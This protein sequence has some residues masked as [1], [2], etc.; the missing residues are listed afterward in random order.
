MLRY[1]GRLC[2][3]NIDNL[4][5]NIVAEAHGS[6]YYIHPGYTKMYNDLKDIYWSEGMKRDISM[7]VD[8]SQFS[9]C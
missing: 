8:E 9:K 4:R 1:Q 7:C 5:T 6:K 2:V 3:T